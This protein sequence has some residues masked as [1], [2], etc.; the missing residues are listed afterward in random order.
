MPRPRRSGGS[1]MSIDL[2]AAAG[3]D[4]RR[5]PD[6]RTAPIPLPPLARF[7]TSLRRSS[8]PGFAAI[9]LDR[10]LGRGSLIANCCCGA[11]IS[12]CSRWRSPPLASTA[13][14]R[15]SWRSARGRSAC[16]SRWRE[17]CACHPSRSWRKVL[18][19][20]GRCCPGRCGTVAGAP[21]LRTVLLD[22]STIDPLAFGAASL[23]LTAVAL[24]ACYVPA[25]RAARSA[26][27]GA[28]SGR[29]GTCSA[30][31][32]MPVVL[33]PQAG[34]SRSPR[35]YARARHR[36]EHGHLHGDLRRVAQA[37]AVRKSDRIVRLTEGRPGF[38]LNESYRTSSTGGGATMCSTG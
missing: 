31:S 26:P 37:A 34:D 22:V 33:L 24:C 4:G 32:A 3:T 19:H 11:T 25:R 23:A 38:R 36:R 29:V 9:P 18:A 28:L 15:M 6:R 20:C 17:P 14:S 21:L 5:P 8:R 12:D 13:C 2:P 16:A 35:S 7:S 10:L 30:T 1:R 27:L